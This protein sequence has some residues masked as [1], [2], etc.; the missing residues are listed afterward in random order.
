MFA[1]SSFDGSA[2]AEQPG[3]PARR[4]FGSSRSRPRAIFK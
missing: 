4:L 1:T 3:L 2:S